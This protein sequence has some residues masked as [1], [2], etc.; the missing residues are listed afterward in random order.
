MGV[1]IAVIRV[2]PVIKITVICQ[3]G[4][5]LNKHEKLHCKCKHIY[6][7]I[8]FVYSAQFQFLSF[9]WFCYVL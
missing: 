4:M 7:L 3:V 6:E 2:L 9:S 5:V 1:L 8:L